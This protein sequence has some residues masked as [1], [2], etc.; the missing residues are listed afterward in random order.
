MALRVDRGHLVVRTGS[1][2]QRAEGR[3]PKVARPRVRRLLIFGR[4]GFTTWDALAWL[5]GIG[6]SFVHLSTAGRIIAAS[7]QP[8]SD[9][10]SLRRVQA[11]AG[12][13]PVG[14]AIAKDL[15]AAKL[16][17]ELANLLRFFP[18]AGPAIATIEGARTLLKRVQTVEEAR[19]V[20]SRAASAY[21][22]AWQGF[23]TRFGRKDADRV[24]EQWRRYSARSSPLA[25]GPRVA[26]DPLN[27]VLNLLFALGEFE[28]RLALLAVGLDP[29]LGFAHADQLSRDSAALDVLEVIRPQIEAYAIETFSTRRFARGDFIER[30]DGNCRVAPHLA[31]ELAETLPAWEAVVGPVAERVARALGRASASRLGRIPTPLTQDNRSAGRDYTRRKARPRPT[32][33]ARPLPA[34]CVACGVVLEASDRTYCDDCLLE[35]RE[36]VLPS[37]SSSGP[38]TLARMRRNGKDPMSKPESKKRLGQ[39]NVRRREEAV[40]WDAEHERPDPE[41]FRREILPGLAEVPLGALMRATGLSKR[42]VWLVRRGGYVPHP[43]H[44]EALRGLT[45]RPAGF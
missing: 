22:L 37:F 21:W 8:G 15:L 12:A 27:G 24:P 39:A 29:G 9:N 11:L 18:D 36:E 19:L 42:Y 5:D 13:G 33:R 20:E 2:R 31:R 43:R 16:D 32:A 30:P 1:G 41:I 25:R 44:W 4:G 6:A 23:E 14:V 28:A 17:G 7:A 45:S 3:F 26:I 34:A 35:R 10:P 38:A 40:A